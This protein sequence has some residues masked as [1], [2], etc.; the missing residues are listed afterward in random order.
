MQAI[1][2]NDKMSLSED[3]RKLIIKYHSEGKSLREIGRIVNKSF[4]TIRNIVNK[5]KYHR[6]IADLPKSGRPKKLNARAVAR[7]CREAKSNPFISAV[8][9]AEN[10]S[11]EAEQS[12]SAST[13]RRILHSNGLFGR[14][15]R[16]KPLISIRNKRRRHEFAKSHLPMNQYFW[17]DV[18]FTDESKFEIFGRNRNGKVWRK[19]N[20]AMK[21]INLLPTVKHGGG[22]VMVW[23]CMAASGVGNLVFIES[24][25]RK[26]SY[27]KILQENLIPSVEK[28]GL[29]ERWTFQQDNDPKHT[30]HIVKDWLAE[31]VP[32]QLD[33]PPQ[34]PD[35]NPIEHLWEHL[36]REIRKHN[37]TNKQMLKNRIS[38]EWA[39][40]PNNVTKNLVDSMQRRM[41][42]LKEARGGPTKY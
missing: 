29:T 28:L 26:E 7:I 41:A 4:S 11:Q 19:K 1:V 18:L 25:M 20:T 35:L 42:A 33:H 17:N 36:D 9:L 31:N 10:V 12:I 39:K 22:N 16:K 38:E 14:S 8:K 13:I 40:I 3:L 5:Y 30:A 32:N 37:I 34:S 15:A 21:E 23:G 24:T 27:L 2:K 6:K